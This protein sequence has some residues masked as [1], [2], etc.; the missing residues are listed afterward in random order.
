[1]QEKI[2]LSS[3]ADQ[4]FLRNE[5]VIRSKSK[6]TDHLFQ[7]CSSLA[8]AGLSL[9]GM[10]VLEVGC[11]NGYRLS[12]LKSLG[13][14]VKGIEPSAKAVE[15]SIQNEI[16]LEHE[17]EQ[18]D[19]ASFFD[20]N[21]KRFDIIL[22]GHS[23]Y[24]VDPE[25]YSKIVHGT[26]SA[27]N[28]GGYIAIFDFNAVPHKRTYHHKDGVYS[29]KMKFARMFDWHPQYQL[30]F[31]NVLEHNGSLSQGDINE[32]CALTAIRKISKDNA[33]PKIGV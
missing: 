8:G 17:I 32:D 28:E 1:M 23:L 14:K 18:N 22:F 2:F 26:M 31:Q 27:L 7:L 11:A 25:S 9:E 13:C 4:W 21:E 33:F 24:L 19:A 15:N 3:E 16:L 29:Y 30:V 20:N 6:E 10:S 12:W 5:E